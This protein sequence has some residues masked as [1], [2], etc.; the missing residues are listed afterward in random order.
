MRVVVG[1]SYGSRNGRTSRKRPVETP[2]LGPV[3]HPFKH[4][5][6]VRVCKRPG[7]PNMSNSRALIT[8]TPTK[9]TSNLQKLPW[10]YQKMPLPFLKH[11][12]T[13][14]GPLLSECTGQPAMIRTT[15]LQ[16]PI[17]GSSA[18]LLGRE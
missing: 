18:Q 8:R 11:D 12:S 2:R 9:R 17:S 15:Q 1:L 4:N 14:P 10:A 5:P 16:E 13:S 3:L 7:G 6:H